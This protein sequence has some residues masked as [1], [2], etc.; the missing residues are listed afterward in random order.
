MRIRLAPAVLALSLLTPIALAGPNIASLAPRDAFALLS[1]DNAQETVAALKR[2]SLADLWNDK[3]VRAYVRSISQGAFDDLLKP[4]EDLGIDVDSLRP[5]SAAAGIA[6]FM[7]PNDALPPDQPDDDDGPDVQLLLIADYA[8]APEGAAA[9]LEDAIDRLV[10]DAVSSERAVSDLLDYGDH[11]ITRITF[12]RE[13]EPEPEPMVEPGEEGDD[14]DFFPMDDEADEPWS[15]SVLLIARVG[16][17]FLASSHLDALHDAIDRAEGKDVGESAEDNPEF[18]AS[19]DMLG[20]RADQHAFAVVFV[21]PL[22]DMLKEAA[23]DDPYSPMGALDVPLALLGVDKVRSAAMSMRLDTPEGAAQSVVAFRVPEKTGLLAL[24]NAEPGPF[25]PPAFVSPDVASVYSMRLDFASLVP[26][27]RN[28]IRNLPEEL[29]A[30]AEPFAEQMLTTVGAITG[31]L[32]SELHM[33]SRISQ[34]YSAT[35]QST[36]VALAVKDPEP[37]IQTLSGIAQGFL[38]FTPRDYLGHQ[39]WESELPMGG[40]MSFSVGAGWLFVGSTA[41]VEDALRESSNPNRPKLADD[42]AFQAAT[43]AVAAPAI[44]HSWTRLR[45]TLE[46]AAWTAANYDKILIEQVRGFG[47][48]PEEEKEYIEMMR[49][50]MPADAQTPVP[51]D[52]ILQHLGDTI[53][54]LRATP[55]GFVGQGILLRPAR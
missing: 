2:S 38:G 50:S 46:F 3:Q 25:A 52:A 34:P 51:V 53:G 29:R 28:T 13:A 16:D 37:V 19:L 55:E 48:D 18:I 54:D 43:R 27:L 45:P 10:K 21:S 35:S 4:W 1:C 8:G 23:A 24:L 7:A 31:G 9:T 44:M 14:Q 6:F 5:P 32:A 47:L 17:A 41:A 42:A 26:T 36:L 15:P 11:D 22:L 49:E 20:A 30:E 33:V 40:G 39:I 12:K